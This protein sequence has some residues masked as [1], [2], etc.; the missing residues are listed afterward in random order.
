[1]KNKKIFFLSFLSIFICILFLSV[2]FSAFSNKLDIKDIS[3]V[4]RVKKDIRIT[5]IKGINVEGNA[6]SSYN[7]Y[8]V[9]NLS[10]SIYLPQ[11]DSKIKY[12]IEVTNFGNVPMAIKSIS[13]LPDY[14]DYKINNYSLNSPICDEKNECKLG[15]KKT[16]ELEIFYKE[17]NKDIVSENIPLNIEFEFGMAKYKINFHKNNENATGGMESLEVGYEE[18]ILLPKNEF[19]LVGYYFKGWTTSPDGSDVIYQDLAKVSKLCSLDKSE[20]N[21]YAVWELRTHKISYDDKFKQILLSESPTTIGYGDKLEI[22]IDESKANDISVVMGNNILKKGTDYI[23]ENNKLIINKVTDDVK[24]N[25]IDKTNNANL[26]LDSEWVDEYT[27]EITLNGTLS[28]TVYMRLYKGD[29]K[30]ETSGANLYVKKYAD[31]PMFKKGDNI[32][33]SYTPISGTATLSSSFTV[34]VRSATESCLAL[35]TAELIEKTSGKTNFNINQPTIK[36]GVLQQD[37]A[38]ISLFSS[39]GNTFNNFK[40][41]ISY[42]VVK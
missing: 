33:I 10:S 11:L 32:F 7:D 14:L 37:I 15:I 13:G 28:N 18:D 12:E 23:L 34:K 1:M 25:F 30:I 36:T 8:N 42:G 24:F 41:R 9:K 17:G 20:I 27:T 3:A 19:S 5:G 39:A 22:D 2:G 16:L 40:F 31:N 38:F 26:S 29:V 4:V 35:N 6:L 21:L